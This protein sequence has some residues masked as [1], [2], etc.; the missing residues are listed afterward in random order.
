MVEFCFIGEKA[1]NKAKKE[2]KGKKI[3]GACMRVGG[4]KEYKLEST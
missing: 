4:E 3:P 1:R 2:R